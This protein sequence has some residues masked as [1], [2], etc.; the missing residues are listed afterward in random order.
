MHKEVNL[1][2]IAFPP[3]IGKASDAIERDAAGYGAGLA[4]EA[5]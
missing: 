1:L 4:G 5:H 2:K 3:Q